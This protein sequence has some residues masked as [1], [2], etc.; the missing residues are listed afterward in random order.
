MRTRGL[1]AVAAAVAL[2]AGACGGTEVDELENACDDYCTLVMRNCQGPVAQYSDLSTC[3]ATCSTMEVGAPGSRDGN[4]IACR[5][6]WAAIAEGEAG[7][8]TSAGPG[9]AGTCGTNCESFC[10]STLAICG[11]QNN[12]PYASTAECVTAC[13]G[14][15]A[16]EPFDASDIAGNTLACRI[17]HMTAA[18]TDPDTHCQHTSVGSVTCI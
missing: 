2:H 11:D 12:P 4:T 13:G 10:A 9:G 18:A 15:S 14:F 1:F 6:F 8:C 16:T 7:E 17:Y 5:T 3:L